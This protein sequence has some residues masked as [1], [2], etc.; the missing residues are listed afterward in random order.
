MRSVRLQ[1]PPMTPA[2]AILLSDLLEEAVSSIWRTYGAGMADFLG[3]VDPEGMP[4][5]EPPDSAAPDPDGECD[6]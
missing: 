2:E 5:Q 4:E 3:C 6:F 1:L